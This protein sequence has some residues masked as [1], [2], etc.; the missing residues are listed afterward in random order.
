VYGVASTRTSKSRTR[1]QR[2]ATLVDEATVPD[3]HTAILAKELTLATH[4][5]H[6]CVAPRELIPA[7]RTEIWRERAGAGALVLPD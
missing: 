4:L 3:K 1:L 2:V 7:G 5:E 6:R